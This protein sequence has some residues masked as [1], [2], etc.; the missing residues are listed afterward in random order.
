MADSIRSLRVE[1]SAGVDGFVRGM[2]TAGGAADTFAKKMKTVAAAR[3]DMARASSRSDD[4]F[5]RTNQKLGDLA[6]TAGKTATKLARSADSFGLPVG[7]L[8][9][10][11]DVMDVAELGFGNLSKSMA[12]FNAAS[13][14]VAGAGLAVGA[15]IGGWLNTFPAVQQAVD[16]VVHSLVNLARSQKDLDA[17]AGATAGIADFSRRMAASNEEAI[18]KQVAQL[19]A[20]GVAVD[21]IAKMYKGRLSPA[22]AESLGLTEKQV[23]AWKKGKADAQAAAEAFAKLVDDLSGKSA[24]AEADQL[25]AAFHRLGVQGVADIE[26]LRRK[27]ED[28]QKQGAKITDKGLLGVLKGGKIDIPKDVGQLD[29]GLDAVTPTPGADLAAV[30]AGVG[31]QTQQNFDAIAAA[32]KKAGVDTQVIAATLEKAGASADQVAIALDRIKTP[33]G[34]KEAFKS[35]LAGLPQVVLAAF[36]GGG[37]VGKSIGSYLGGSILDGLTGEN[38]VLGKKLS[39]LLGKTLGGAIG[40]ILPGLGSILGAGLGSIAGKALSAIG[41]LFGGEEKEVNKLRDAFL[42]AQGGFVE[43]Q[44]KLVGLTNKDL[45][46][47]IFDAK[48]V[49]DFNAAVREVTDLLGLQTEAQ[50]AVDDAMQRYGIEAEK[51]GG[52][53]ASAALEEHA[54]QLYKDWQVLAAKGA[55]LVY[56]GEKMS[57]SVNEYI[58]AAKAA[59][60]TVPEAMRP[61]LETML[62]NGQLLDENGQAY[63]SLEAAGIT[64]G[65]TQGEMWDTLITKV[66]QLVSA[67]LGIPSQVPVDVPVNVHYPNG[68]PPVGGSEPA[69]P[70]DTPGFATGGWGNFGTGTLAMLHGYEAIV[71]T[72]S[73]GRAKGGAGKTVISTSVQVNADPFQTAESRRDME[74]RLMR[75]FE[76]RTSR[77]LA[78]SIAAGRA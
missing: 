54:Q 25:A 32:A 28:L 53:I 18:K 66:D 61:M 49:K 73:S 64:F 60:Q 74:R 9:A 23:D 56:V 45:V 27:L 21:D 62:K 15:A 13:L 24:Q 76:R 4:S 51:A 59:G 70:S 72:D 37:N 34:L 36:Q 78:A 16:G 67:L 42:S 68:K 7:P 43:L 38:G 8:R 55:D 29:L 33:V 44:K 77:R 75:T 69:V 2:S 3:D 41:K 39:G 26:A 65:K 48:T 35:T 20:H 52:A 57:G 12:G 46:K 5:T 1:L 10:L 30:L 58:A 47:R 71:P 6:D 63:G 11:D 14:G 17:E 31:G 22:L 40:S 50:Q 19:K